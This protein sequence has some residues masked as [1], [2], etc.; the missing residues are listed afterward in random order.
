MRNVRGTFNHTTLGLVACA[1][2]GNTSNGPTN[3]FVSLPLTH[4]FNV[5]VDSSTLSPGRYCSRAPL[6]PCFS[7][8]RFAR[9]IASRVCVIVA[10]IASAISSAAGTFSRGCPTFAGVRG[11]RARFTEKRRHARN[12]RCAAIDCEFRHIQMLTPIFSGPITH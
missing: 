5:L 8:A 7:Y 4:K 6:L 12:A 3:L 10:K 1:G 9:C 11:S 2:G